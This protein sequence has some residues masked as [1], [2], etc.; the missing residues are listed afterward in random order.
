ME[1]A[2]KVLQQCH[3]KNENK[4][5][6]RRA[7]LCHFQRGDLVLVKNRHAGS[8]FLLPFEVE[9]WRVSAV[10]GTMITA[11]R[12]GEPIMRN[13][14]FFKQYPQPEPDS[15]STKLKTELNIRLYILN[16]VPAPYQDGDVVVKV[17]LLLP[18]SLCDTQSAWRLVA[19][20]GE[21]V[22]SEPHVIEFS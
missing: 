17:C 19:A 1:K 16:F 6:K 3:E 21:A 11:E 4:S 20:A 18:M 13:G 8:H 12:Q 15:G 10:K 5:K 22:V 2:A 14:S 9:P 7:K